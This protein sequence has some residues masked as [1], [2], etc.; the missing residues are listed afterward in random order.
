VDSA[1][2][3]PTPLENIAL[4]PYN[5]P[6]KALIDVLFGDIMTTIDFYIL[7]Q[8]Q[9][10]D[11]HRFVCNLV[12]KVYGEGRNIYI[13]TSNEADA[14]EL[15]D[16]LWSFKGEAF[17]PHNIIGDAKLAE[18]QVQIG[19]GEHP[20]HHHDVLINLSSPQPNFF[21]RFQRVLEVVIQDEA[22]LSQTRQ[23]YK[24]YK[25]RGYQVTYRDLRV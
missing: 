17:I 8:T 7:G 3:T 13:H 1:L 12:S 6:L 11:R 22:I 14:K 5:R 16:L 20:D 10:T 15:D 2:N 9:T 19:W 4:S 24:F 21:S 23:H 25:E 18:T